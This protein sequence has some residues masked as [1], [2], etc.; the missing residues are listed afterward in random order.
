M[1]L[2]MAH[3]LNV[4]RPPRMEAAAAAAEGP[5][6]VVE[7][8]VSLAEPPEP[9][10]P[11]AGGFVVSGPE[12]VLDVLLI[13]D[14]PELR[15]A[16]GGG[17]ARRRAPGDR[18]QRRRRGAGPGHARRCSTSSSATCACP[19][20]DGLTLLRRV[21]QESPAHRRH[22]DDRLRRG[23]RRGRR[24]QGGRLRL[25]HQAVRDRRAAVAAQAHRPAPRPC[26]R[27]LEQARAELAGRAARTPRSSGSSPPMRRVLG[28]IE[29]VG[30]RATRPTLVTGESGTGK[31]LVARMLHERSARRDK[32]VRGGQLRRADRDADRGRAV[33]PRARAPSPARSRKRDGRF[34]AADGGTLFLDEIAELPLSAQAKLL[35]VLQEGTFEPLGT[36]TTMKVDVRVVSATHR[37]LKK[38]I[39]EGTVPRG[40]L[41]P[42]QRH[43]D[44]TAAAARAARATCRCC[45]STSCS[46]SRPPG[47]RCR[48]CRRRAWAALCQLRRSRATCASSRTPSSTRWCCRAA[49]RSTSSTCPPA[50]PPAPGRERRRRDARR[51][52]R[53]AAPAA[54]GDQGVR[55]RVPAA[56]HR[57]RPAASA[58]RAAEM[59]GISRKSLW[60]KLRMHGISDAEIEAQESANARS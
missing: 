14:E 29:M 31:E 49:A 11:D 44:P 19:S 38:R 2:I 4:D 36:N 26:A 17:A 59:L 7:S 40:S 45:C 33:R 39:A 18:G 56:R 37:N 58:V 34:K 28:L 32:P 13:D 21:R 24:A 27:E 16:A 51:Q 54:A 3:P 43:R 52:R 15:A 5:L 30:R 41:L 55:A 42:D 12:E 60:E 46:A 22:P 20:V 53:A 35:R 25:P 1:T 50:S 10:E 23:G 6:S 8:P 47:G 48:R 9:P 57:A